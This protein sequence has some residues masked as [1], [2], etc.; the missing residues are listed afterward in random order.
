MKKFYLQTYGCKFNQVDSE[1]I[2]K[3]LKEKYKEASENEAD[4][5]VLNTCGVVE[6]T[7]RKIIKRAIELKEKGKPVI[8]AGCLSSISPN[9]TKKFADGAIGTK[10]IFFLPKVVE[11]VLEGKRSYYLKKGKNKKNSFSFFPKNSVTSII[12]IS[13]GCLSNC[14]YCATKFARGKLRSFDEDKILE[15]VK[16]AILKG[17]K[18][19]QLTSQNLA[20]YGLDRGGLF[21]PKLLKRILEIKGDFKVR[22]GM[23][24]PFFAKKILKDLLSLMEDEKIYKFLHLPLQS[25]DDK[26]LKSMGRNYKVKDFLEIVGAFREK[27]KDSLLATDII[28]GFPTESEKEFLNTVKIIKETKPEILHLFRYSKRKGTEAEKL[29]DFPERIK[30][31]RSRILSKIWQKI[32]IEKNKK[33]LGKSFEVLLVEKRKKSFLA[34]LNSFRAVVLKEGNLGERKIVKIVGAKPNY[35]IGEPESIFTK[36]KEPSYLRA[37]RVELL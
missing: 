11:K 34:R 19:I 12:S 26:V 24:E 30:K 21:L 18:E 8:F 27:F 10:N 14:T 36:E 3:I 32:I 6:K 9:L 33:F 13:E 23:M 28:V 16:K 22:L 4:F 25:G 31:E 37:L 7:E 5:F 2:R 20:I 35:L 1:L 15:N 17:K 29:K